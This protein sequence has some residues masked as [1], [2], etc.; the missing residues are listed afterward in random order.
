M[1][2]LNILNTSF[3]SIYLLVHFLFVT[4]EAINAYKAP[5]SVDQPIRR[6]NFL[7][8]PNQN[9]FDQA[10]FSFQLQAKI[11]K[12][13]HKGELFVIVTTSSEEMAEKIIGILKIKMP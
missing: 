2:H 10:A 11:M 1:K 4:L 8:S 5:D 6:L 12:M 9:K 13:F 3:K 7:V